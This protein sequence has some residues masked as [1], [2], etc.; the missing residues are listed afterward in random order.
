M[1]IYIIEMFDNDE[2]GVRERGEVLAK[3]LSTGEMDS[4]FIE[5]AH[6]IA[7]EMEKR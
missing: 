3:T 1:K 2:T 4:K 6:E 5:S 7:T